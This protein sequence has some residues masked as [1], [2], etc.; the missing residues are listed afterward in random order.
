M[1]LVKITA[2]SAQA[3]DPNR[4]NISVDGK[5][6]FSLDIYQ[7]A[8]LG[9]RLGKEYSQEELVN[10]EQESQFG[11]LYSRAL[12]YTMLRPHSAKEV[13]DYLYRKTRT[14]K[15]RSR[16]GEI[17]ERQ[18]FSQDLV[19]RVYQRLIEKGH[20]DD[21]RFARYWVE[22][23]NLRKGS[24]RRK[25]QAEL[26]SKGVDRSIIE[27]QLEHSGRSDEDEL[28]KVIAKKQARYPDR[29]KFIAYLARQ[30]FSYDDIT[31]ALSED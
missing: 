18:G 13:R 23:R 3:K 31:A 5:Y 17:K 4:V 26:A 8:D 22:N 11:K 20:I 7:V 2:I 25:L 28:Q 14:T 1:Q 29:Q 19:D 12:E 27:Q 30:G 24:S 10:L 16:T 6:R 9:V 21:E 15:Y